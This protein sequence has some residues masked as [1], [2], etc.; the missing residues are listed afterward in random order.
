MSSV[1]GLLLFYFWAVN[2]SRCFS[3]CLYTSSFY[4]FYFTAVP[5]SSSCV[6]ISLCASFV[7][8]ALVFLPE[9]YSAAYRTPFLS[10]PVDEDVFFCPTRIRWLSF[11]CFFCFRFCLCF[12]F[13]RIYFHYF[14][15]LLCPF[16]AT[17]SFAG[18]FPVCMLLSVF[19]AFFS[20][21]VQQY[22]G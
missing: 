14:V 5:I 1:W 6:F 13:L 3:L 16:L 2:P 20:K 9:F 15:C 11:G 21:I 12:G 4:L 22:F 18:Y 7:V 19:P 8:L 17:M 10:W